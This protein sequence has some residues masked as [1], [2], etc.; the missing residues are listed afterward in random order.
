MG[1]GAG[2][3]DVVLPDGVVVVPVGLVVTGLPAAVILRLPKVVQLSCSENSRTVLAE[4]A[5]GRALGWAHL[6][7]G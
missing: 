5:Q 7:S 6:R 1:A 4:S 3:G 2:V